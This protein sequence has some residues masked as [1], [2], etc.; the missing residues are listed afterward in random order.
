MDCSCTQRADNF[1]AGPPMSHGYQPDNVEAVCTSINQYL[2][3]KNVFDDTKLPQQT[4]G[5]YQMPQKNERKCR[6]CN[7]GN[8][9][10][11]GNVGAPMPLQDPYGASTPQYTAAS[12]DGNFA[13]KAPDYSISIKFGE[14]SYNIDCNADNYQQQYGGQPY[15]ANQQ[16]YT[17]DYNMNNYQQQYGDPRGAQQWS[18]QQGAQQW[19]PGYNDAN[20]YN[21]NQDCGGA[22]EQYDCNDYAQQ[23]QNSDCSSNAPTPDD[24]CCGTPSPTAFEQNYDDPSC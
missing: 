4:Q 20:N 12:N 8:A 11:G 6:A 17:N 15:Q 1:A 13:P 9:S 18:P 5:N 21:Y 14:Q 22:Q 7:G 10:R 16:A 19:S 3:Q 23:T 24:N 2:Q